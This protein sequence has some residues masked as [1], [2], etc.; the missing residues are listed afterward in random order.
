MAADKLSLYAMAVGFPVATSVL[1]HFGNHVSADLAEGR[2]PLV[3]QTYEYFGFQF[4]QNFLIYELLF[5]IG[6]FTWLLNL[7]FYNLLKMFGW[8]KII[9]DY[10]QA[11][12]QWVVTPGNPINVKSVPN[13]F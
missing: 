2:T 10:V 7:M 6:L 8:D 4:D 1:M 9:D 5:F 3:M 12:T 11:L 13:P